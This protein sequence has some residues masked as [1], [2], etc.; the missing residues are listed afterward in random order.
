M[1]AVNSWV[2]LAVAVALAACAT[3][4]PAPSVAKGQTIAPV[5]AEIAPLT[6]QTSAGPASV[7]AT[8]TAAAVAASA[9][10]PATASATPQQDKFEIP[11]GFQQVISHGKKIAL[12]C[13]TE[14]I[15]GSRLNKYKVCRTPDELKREQ[16]IARRLI[17]NSTRGNAAVSAGALGP[18]GQGTLMGGP[19]NYTPSPGM[20]SYNH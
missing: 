14:A 16:E 11:D 7:Q 18:Y 3:Q 1:R 19:G 10:T 9:S 13:R 5:T 15:T 4:A 2:I 8:S 12:Y 17:D 20:P 6:A